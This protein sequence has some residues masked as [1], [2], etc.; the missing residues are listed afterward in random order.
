VARVFMGRRGR[1]EEPNVELRKLEL[2][3]GIEMYAKLLQLGIKEEKGAP[4]AQAR[5]QKRGD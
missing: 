2:F 4:N 5:F 1:L 3:R